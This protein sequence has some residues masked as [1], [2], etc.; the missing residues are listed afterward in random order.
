MIGVSGNVLCELKVH[1]DSENN[2]ENE[3]FRLGKAI[4]KCD[5]GVSKPSLD[6]NG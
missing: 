3:K 2:S 1:G 4:F 5:D 6:E